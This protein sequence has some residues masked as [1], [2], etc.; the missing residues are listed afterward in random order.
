MN[1][2]CSTVPTVRPFSVKEFRSFVFDGFKEWHGDRYIM[3]RDIES[4]SNTLPEYAA[5]GWRFRVKCEKFQEDWNDADAW[6]EY[7]CL[8]SAMKRDPFDGTE[9]EFPILRQDISF[10][11]SQLYPQESCRVLRD[12]EVLGIPGE[13]DVRDVRGERV[14]KHF[15]VQDENCYPVN[16]PKP[17][18]LQLAGGRIIASGDHVQA[19]A[20]VSENGLHF[21]PVEAASTALDSFE[22]EID[23]QLA[24]LEVY[25]LN[26]VGETMKVEYK[27]SLVYP[28][29]KDGGGAEIDIKE[30]LG[31]ELMSTLAGFMNAQGGELLVGV[32]NDGSV[33]GIE[34][35]LNYLTLELDEEKVRSY[36]ADNDGFQRCLVDTMQARL[37]KAALSLVDSCKLMRCKGHLIGY[38]RV[39]PS[40]AEVPVYLNGKYLFVRVASSTRRMKGEDAARFVLER[41]RRLEA[42]RTANKG[43]KTSVENRVESEV[44]RVHGADMSGDNQRGAVKEI[45]ETAA[46]ADRIAAYITIYENGTA[47]KSN[48]EQTASGIVAS[49]PVYSL[50]MK[51]DGRLL[52]CYANGR[53]NVLRP[54]EVLTKKLVKRNRA[55]SNSLC[56][57]SPLVAMLVGRESDLLVLET[58]SG[59]DLYRKIV[60]IA[61]YAT[62]DPKSMAT[63]GN[64][65][66]KTEAC[67]QETRVIA[68]TIVDMRDSASLGELSRKNDYGLGNMVLKA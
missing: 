45:V 47:V 31:W 11:L 27:S 67:Q 7:R 32:K 34:Q 43:A 14:L 39:L 1:I 63:K 15:L 21:D 22:H 8:V 55:Y 56:L 26:T 33:V 29:A 37:G 65:V 62:H 57:E 58:K 16:C 17:A 66:V 10:I 68:A 54:K 30:Q 24:S 46:S 5:D 12:F 13:K 23:A 18:M 28:A 52:M 61:E 36:P 59:A 53:V 48:K 6:P 19:Y 64:L 35:D 2:T 49:V 60:P 38:V 9:T 25:K 40:F 4:G 51:K 42:E 44:H 3:L 50:S 20:V 41:T